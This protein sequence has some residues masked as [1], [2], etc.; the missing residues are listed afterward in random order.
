[1]LNFLKNIFKSG[2][3][4]SIIVILVL[5]GG[6]YGYKTFFVAKQVTRYVTTKASKGTLIVSVSGSGQVSAINQVEVKSKVS[7]DIKYIAVVNGQEVRAGNLIAQLDSRDAEKSVRD[8]E[9]NLESAKLALDK[10]NLQSSQQARGDALNINYSNGMN[11]L[12]KLYGE[13]SADLEGLK[14]IYFSIDLSSGSQHICDTNYS[15]LDDCNITYYSNYNKQFSTVPSQILALYKK[16]G[17]LYTQSIADYQTAKISGNN[18]ARSKAIKEGHDLVVQMSEMIKISRD[19]VQSFQ[20]TII[21]NGGTYDKKNIVDGQIKSL[22][23]YSTAMTGY[24]KDL[25]DVVNSANNYF[26]SIASQPID[27]KSQELSIQKSENALLDA[28]DKLADYYVRAPFNGIIAKVNIK[29]TDTISSGTSVVT[30]VTKQQ[31]AEISLNEVDIAKIK[32]NQ[33]ATLTFD[34][35]PD[36]SISGNVAEIDSVGTVSQGVVTYTLKIAFDTQDPRIKPSMSVSAS[37][38]TD[39]KID[40]LVLPNGAVKSDKNGEYVEAIDSNNI[41]S[42]SAPVNGNEIILINPPRRVDVTIGLSND[43]QTEILSGVKE[44]DE[45]VSRTILPTAAKTTTAPSIFGSST[46]GAVRTG[47]ATGGAVRVPTGR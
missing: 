6:Y 28:K 11:I 20:D 47:G 10:L 44:G 19:V 3:A 23:D 1:M 34:A 25:L 35:V 29:A 17:E 38:I 12:S 33:K 24:E 43:T 22:A 40:V 9:A 32:V 41:D 7:G 5:V 21:K 39:S 13:F 30:M 18:E 8:A 27:L 45:F 46:G 26:D 42:S 37:I 14:N 31:V 36:L 15:Q 4:K 2:I 16:I